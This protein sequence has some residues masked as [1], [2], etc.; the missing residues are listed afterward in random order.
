[1]IDLVEHRFV[2]QTRLHVDGID[3]TAHPLHLPAHPLFLVA[4]DKGP[5]FGSAADK[6]L[7]HQQR[8]QVFAI[9][10][11]FVIAIG[12]GTVEFPIS[13]APLTDFFNDNLT[14]KPSKSHPQRKRFLFRHTISVAIHVGLQADAEVAHLHGQSDLIIR[15]FCG[16]EFDFSEGGGFDHLDPLGTSAVFFRLTGGAQTAKRGGNPFLPFFFFRLDTAAPH[17]LQQAGQPRLHP[18]GGQ[19]MIEG[20]KNHLIE[21]GLGQTDLHPLGNKPI[22]R[23][24]HLTLPVERR[25]GLT[26]SDGHTFRQVRLGRTNSNARQIVTR[27]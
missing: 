2:Q 15:K 23:I 7:R 12:I 14:P 25:H 8:R 4:F 1:M 10:R 6:L 20:R 5:Q 24:F 19:K 3:R 18:V 11:V 17:I 27:L 13:P 22:F 16:F 9:A 21:K 26:P